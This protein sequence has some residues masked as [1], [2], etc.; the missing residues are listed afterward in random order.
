[1]CGITGIFAYNQVGAFYM[2][3]LGASMEQLSRRGPDQRGS[4]VEDFVAL[5]HRRLS[6]LDTSSAGRQP[7]YD[8]S[9]NYVIIFNG[10]IFNYRELRRQ[11]E[12]KGISFTSGTDTEVLLKLYIQKGEKCLDELIGFFSFAVYDKK[13][14]TLFIA[15]DRFGVKPLLYFHDEDKFIFASEMKA[16]LRYNIPH[17]IDFASLNQYLHFNYIP[18]P[19]SIIKNVWKLEPGHYLKVRKKTVDKVCWYNTSRFSALNTQ[20]DYQQACNKLQ[21]LLEESVKS[22]LIADVPLG[23]FLSGGVDSSIV[24][25]LASRHKSDLHTF[26]IGFSDQP[27]FDETRYASIVS[28]AFNTNHTSFQLTNKELFEHFSEALDYIDEPFADS[29]ALAMYILSKKT[30]GSVKTVL[31]GDGADEIFAGYNK[32]RA[33]LLV[34]NNALPVKIA[35]AGSWLWNILPADRSSKAGNTI[36]Q[37]RKLAEGAGLSAA[38][39]YY[40]W[41]GFTGQGGLKNLVETDLASSAEV[42]DEYLSRK[43]HLTRHIRSNNF[44]EI[45]LSDVDMVL[46][47]DMLYKVDMMSMANGLEVRSPFLDHRVVEFAFSLPAAWKITPES[48]KRILKD[49]F[50]QTLPAEILQRS[51][52]GFEVPLLQWLKTDMKGKINND[53]LAPDFIKEQKIF[54]LGEINALKAKLYS[55]NP[56]DIHA[57]LWGLIVFQSWY[58]K[59][60]LKQ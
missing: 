2:I 37:L 40:Q 46:Q 16:L 51:K 6:I 54:N 41:A 59:F 15:R 50:A 34:R 56:G 60:I 11:L 58:K 27:Y 7:M 14:N 13:E 53:F 32:H 22:R 38:D 19:A 4:F 49:S 44:N 35:R 42:K 52:K 36:R 25:A 10:E 12:L 43:K 26:S 47:G 17:D 8:E 48:G 55:S 33:E 30:A 31:S 24:T 29:S 20:L 21:E 18:G 3:N 9:E 57:R 5:G 1:M 39:R 28:K 23:S 45:L